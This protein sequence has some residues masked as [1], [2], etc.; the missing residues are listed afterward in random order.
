MPD[1]IREG[2][3][4]MAVRTPT[5][6]PATHTNLLVIGTR[7]AV[8]VEPATPYDD[9]LDR[10]VEWLGELEAHEGIELSAIVVTHH[11]VDHVGGARALAEALRLPVWAHAETASRI[12][13]RV[14]TD[15]LLEEGDRLPLGESTL[16]AVH[17]PGHAPG[18]LCFLEE[19]TGALV[20]GDMVAGVGTVLIEPTDGDMRLYLASLE[21][22]R[23]LG[24]S[25]LIPAHGDALDEPDAVLRHYV[26]HRLARE[27]K[28]RRALQ[29]ADGPQ[30][31]GALLPI[32]YADA[33]RAAWPLA[34]LSLEAHLI[35]LAADGEAVE[36]PDGW[37]RA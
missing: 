11:H 16:R 32:V 30:R 27:A 21:R 1:V 15:R 29:E 5:L 13:G 23:T 12:A 36:T 8:L 28:V 35:K 20:A 10:V 37:A 25:T 31:I 33:P 4:R 34:T 17:T 3:R 2:V 18:H 24:A 9:E 26:A 6:P 14:R 19:R 22:M 7:E